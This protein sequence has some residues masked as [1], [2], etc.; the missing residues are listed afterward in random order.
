M[1]TTSVAIAPAAGPPLW[2]GTDELRHLLPAAFLVDAVEEALRRAGERAASGHG[3]LACDVDNGAFHVKATALAG[4]RPVY[5]AKVNANFPGNSR[6]GLPTIQ[7]VVALFDA[8]DG[9]LLALLDSPELTALRTGAATAVA[10]RYLARRDSRRLLICGAGRQAAAQA[11]MLAAVLPL[12]EIS[13]LDLDADRARRFAERL[14]IELG[15]AASITEDLA[16]SAAESDVIVTCTTATRPFLRR[17]HVLPGTFVAAVGADH[18]AKQELDVE[19]VAAARCFV[20][21]PAQALHCGEW[22]HAAAAGVVSPD[23]L[24]GRLDELVTGTVV[25]RRSPEEITLFDSTGIAIED[26]AAALAAFE[27]QQSGTAPPEE[28]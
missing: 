25:G 14:G 2:L 17:E 3:A 23:D 22:H 27:R 15:L 16:A 8:R 5:V 1:N 7:G 19:L 10:A 4:V 26:A 11:S 21:S 28:R 6:H 18:P 9:R 24:A 13:V 20:D 12:D